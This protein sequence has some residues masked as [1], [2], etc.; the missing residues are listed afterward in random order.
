M[1]RNHRD[2]SAWCERAIE[3]QAGSLCYA[4][5]GRLIRERDWDGFWPRNEGATQEP[6]HGFNLFNLY[7]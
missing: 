5:A 6:A 2:E 3:R 4:A 1:A 7:V